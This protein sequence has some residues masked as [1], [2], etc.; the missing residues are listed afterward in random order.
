MTLQWPIGGAEVPSL[1]LAR[2]LAKER[3]PLAI[4]IAPRDVRCMW[5]G[6]LLTPGAPCRGSRL[7]LVHVECRNAFTR[8][9]VTRSMRP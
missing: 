5:C 1:W 3:W 4:A 6:E 8:A 7:R 2:R 9:P